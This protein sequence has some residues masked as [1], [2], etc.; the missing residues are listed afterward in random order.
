MVETFDEEI[1][2]RRF[3]VALK[4]ADWRMFGDAVARLGEELEAGSPF[5]RLA[6][7]RELVRKADAHEELPADLAEG[8]R[9]MVARVLD[10]DAR[11]LGVQAAAAADGPAIVVV[12]LWRSGLGD[13]ARRAAFR[14]WLARPGAEAAAPR[15]GRR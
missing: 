4:R 9:G 6:D 10:V 2:L 1:A 8:L 11:V 3:E 14:A 5:A 12:D 7:W 13:P 15:R